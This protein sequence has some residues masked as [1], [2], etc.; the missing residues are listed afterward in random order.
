[1][2]AYKQLLQQRLELDQKI[3][4]ARQLE[5]SAAVGQIRALVSDFQL[6]SE[7]V[8][9]STSAAG[10][11]RAVTSG[12]KVAPKYSDPVSGKTWTG[13]GKAPKWIEGQDRTSF[14]I[15]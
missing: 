12:N 2:S 13:R 10:K 11:V 9:P 15:V 7:D 6:T 3:S 1:M 4:E 5:I 8:F 14:L